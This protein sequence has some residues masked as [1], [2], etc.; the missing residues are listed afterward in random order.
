AFHRVRVDVS[1]LVLRA[2]DEVVR[3]PRGEAAHVRAESALAHHEGLATRVDRRL[4]RHVY[5]VHEVRVQG[6]HRVG[7]C[8]PRQAN[9]GRRDDARLE[10]PAEPRCF[11]IEEM[12]EDGYLLDVLVRV[13]AHVPGP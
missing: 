2:D 9:G 13:T 3:L 6:G 10:D 4:V 7:W 5:E 8:S 12:R 1:R 11:L